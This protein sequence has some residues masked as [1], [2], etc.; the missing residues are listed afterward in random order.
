VSAADGT[1]WGRDADVAL[2]FENH[3]QSIFS[4]CRRRLGSDEDAEDALQTTFVHAL[5]SVRR[6]VRPRT[7]AA[8]LYAI[9]HNVCRERWRS[10]HGRDVRLRAHD[11]DELAD[12]LAAPEP[13]NEELFDLDSALDRLAERQREALLLREWRGLSYA[14]IAQRLAVSEAAVETL[15]YRARRALA[16]ELEQGRQRT[17]GLW[18]PLGVLVGLPRRLWPA[19]ATAKLAAGTA[20]VSIAV[21]AGGVVPRI[22]HHDRA[23]VP[24]AAPVIAQRA[25]AARPFTPRVATPKHAPRVRKVI[26]RHAS[27]V[28]RAG[29][30]SAR[31][32]AQSVAMPAPA[33]SRSAMPA[34]VPPPAPAAADT[35]PPPAAPGSAAPT[36][37][38]APPPAAAEPATS[39]VAQPLASLPA[40]PT[41]PV[42]DAL[43][44]AV[45]TV[46]QLPVPPQ[47]PQTV[48]V[49]PVQVQT[50]LP[51]LPSLPA[52]P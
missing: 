5:R 18:A 37:S 28:A 49:G 38:A 40:L 50:N 35:S 31:P 42:T 10:S 8:W 17:R 19:G 27:P 29:H 48:D 11:V 9:A 7:E 33:A 43:T 13:D 32:P 36:A 12:V 22:A 41:T 4:Y 20:A 14:E 34:P 46:I 52:L 15:L 25:S 23:P 6:G 45:E 26:R 24:R 3:R 47:L 16:Q 1:V 30:V 21:L 51:P 44:P 2:L 39:T